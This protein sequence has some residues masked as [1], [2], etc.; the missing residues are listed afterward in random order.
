MTQEQSSDF[1]RLR[2][3]ILNPAEGKGNKYKIKAQRH[4]LNQYRKK[5]KKKNK[6]MTTMLPFIM[7]QTSE[8]N[9]GY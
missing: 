9:V 4:F 3:E 5:K 2:P 8:D 1:Q 6:T 7:R